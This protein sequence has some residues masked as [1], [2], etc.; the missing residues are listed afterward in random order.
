MSPPYF[1]PLWGALEPCKVAKLTPFEFI[2]RQVGMVHEV[3][4]GCGWP[5]MRENTGFGSPD[6]GK[7]PNPNKYF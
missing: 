5:A 6:L 3:A 7:Q 4:L 1:P 2:E